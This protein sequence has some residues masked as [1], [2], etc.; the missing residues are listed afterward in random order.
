MGR[1][2]SERAFSQTSRHRPRLRAWIDAEPNCE[3]NSPR[4][5]T[6][7]TSTGRTGRDRRPL[8]RAAMLFG[9]YSL[10][11]FPIKGL[12]ARGAPRGSSVQFISPGTPRNCRP[13][14][15]RE[16]ASSVRSPDSPT[17]S[18][19][20][21]SSPARRSP[22]R[23]KPLSCSARDCA[24][25]G[26]ASS[27]PGAASRDRQVP[28]VIAARIWEEYARGSVEPAESRGEE[29]PQ[30]D[31]P[32]WG[33]I[34]GGEAPVPSRQ[35]LQATRRSTGNVRPEE[36][37]AR[38][39]ED[40]NGP[41]GS[42]LA[43]I[44]DDASLVD[45]ES[46]E[47]LLHLSNRARLRPLLLVFVLDN[48]L[49]AYGVWD[50]GL[51]GRSDVDWVRFSTSRPDPR[52][53]ARLRAQ[54]R[55]LAPGGA[56]ARSAGRPPGGFELPGAAGP[57]RPNDPGPGC[58]DAPCSGDRQPP[59]DPRRT[60]EPRGRVV[61]PRLCRS[62]RRAGAPRVPSEDRPRAPGDA[63]GTHR[64]ATRGDRRAPVR[65]RQGYRVPPRPDCGGDRPG[66]GA[67][68]RRGRGGRRAGDRLRRLP[69]HR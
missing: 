15:N 23:A 14:F 30:G 43:I 42:P 38:F 13:W 56:T 2:G 34:P 36:F 54:M 49:P 21:S 37:L 28:H 65:S 19:A 41:D 8:R 32:A 39:T 31:M 57:D 11:Q 5:R 47:F 44:V 29:L 60:R 1:R 10:T 63:P 68:P 48:S 46:R 53:V 45:H 69:R 12:R 50:E 17:G 26:S 6:L 25:E 55:T 16:R 61:G 59:E 66:A 40:L 22:A 62:D 18:E 52:D 51:A 64:G 27:W 58:G 9:T 35:R 3:S 67:P 7:V 24:K 33:F 4:S 20:P